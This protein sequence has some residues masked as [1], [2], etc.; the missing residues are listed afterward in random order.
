MRPRSWDLGGW[1]DCLESRFFGDT[2]IAFSNWSGRIPI[3]D[4]QPPNV[5]IVHELPVKS[6]TLQLMSRWAVLL[7]D[8]R[9]SD[10]F[11]WVPESA[12]HQ[13]MRVEVSHRWQ[14]IHQVLSSEQCKSGCFLILPCQSFPCLIQVAFRGPCAPWEASHR[15]LHGSTQPRS[16]SSSLRRISSYKDAKSDAIALFWQERR[17]SISGWFVKSIMLCQIGLAVA[18]TV[19]KQSCVLGCQEPTSLRC[20]L[21]KHCQRPSWWLAENVVRNF[22]HQG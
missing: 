16:S 17:Q 1:K 2:G 5:Q 14:S 19:S 21:K 11:Q 8:K 3:Q 15:Y 12:F 6:S 7:G 9:R 18:T 4:Q 10:H 22:L 13:R 20:A